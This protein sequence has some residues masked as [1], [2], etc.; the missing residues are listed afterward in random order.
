[1]TL[2]LNEIHLL[3][4]LKKTIMVAAADRRLSKPDG[5]YDSTRRKLFPICY[6]NGAI[7]YFGLAS[8]F[9]NGRR[10]YLSEWLPNFIRG[11]SNALDLGTFANN[12][13]SRLHEVVPRAILQR[14]PSGFHICGYNNFGLPEFWSLTNIGRLEGFQHVDFKAQYGP[15]SAD[16]LGRDAKELG[17]DGSDPSSARNVTWTYRNGDFRAHVAAWESLDEILMKMFQFP[18]FRRPSNVREY[19]DYIRFKF[20]FIAYLYKKWARKILIGRPIDVI[21]LKSSFTA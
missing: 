10:T 16:F 15:P 7:S 1:M 20:E 9:P 4:G 18:D 19:E 3:D 2:V 21:V 6:L 14:N 13:R 11:Q 12:L 8:V 17:W 5:S